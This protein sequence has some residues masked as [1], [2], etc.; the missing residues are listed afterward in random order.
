M[1]LVVLYFTLIGVRKGTS[2]IS[3]RSQI[4]KKVL[5]YFFLNPHKKV[6]VN[7]LQ[8]QLNVDKRNLVKKLKELTAE[9]ILQDEKEANL[10]YYSVNE[11]YPLY[12]EY[13]RI[14][15]KTAGLEKKLKD[16]LKKEKK[17]EEAYIYGSYAEDSM[18][19]KSDID[20]LVIGNHSIL[21]LQRKINKLEEEIDRQI[22]IINMHRQEYEKRIKSKDPFLE[23]I[24]GKEYIKLT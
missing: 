9:G 8:R 13:K 6:Y 21:S 18:D 7:A 14:I 2:M 23:S 17:V 20:L 24:F 10:R 15:L 12:K 22:N 19:A 1:T 3:L 11:S 16:I 5:S 4:T